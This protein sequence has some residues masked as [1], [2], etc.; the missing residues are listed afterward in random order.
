MEKD[1]TR[2]VYE[3]II[4]SNGDLSAALRILQGYIRDFSAGTFPMLP[5]EVKLV[6][7]AI[8][9]LTAIQKV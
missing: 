5:D 9:R 6:T 1:V 2:F 3:L 8:A 4:A 7:L